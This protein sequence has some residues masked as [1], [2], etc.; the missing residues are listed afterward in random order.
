MAQRRRNVE[1]CSLLT[2]SSTNTRAYFPSGACRYHTVGIEYKLA[3]RPLVEIL[4]TLRRFLKWDDRSIDRFSD[5]HFVVEDRHH[6]L[7]VIAHDRA[8]ASCKRK[9]LGPA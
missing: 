7:A 3:S 1:P 6:K 4:I 9:R 8:L 5:L 2:H